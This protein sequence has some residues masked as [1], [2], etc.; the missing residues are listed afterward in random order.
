M[1]ICDSTGLIHVHRA[2]TAH[3]TCCATHLLCLGQEWL[4]FPNNFQG[5]W[6]LSG[7]I[8]WDLLGGRGTSSRTLPAQSFLK[9]V[10]CVCV[11]QPPD[12]YFGAWVFRNGRIWENGRLGQDW[13]VCLQIR[14]W[15]CLGY[16]SQRSSQASV[17]YLLN[18]LG[19]LIRLRPII[20]PVW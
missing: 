6:S 17:F 3:V 11:A 12:K 8:W 9:W 19:E 18:S 15:A 5:I 16:V 14:S 1:V 7:M 20:S 13:P 4:K 10:V 2:A